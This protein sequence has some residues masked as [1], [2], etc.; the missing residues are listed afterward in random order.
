MFTKGVTMFKGVK[1]FA[2]LEWLATKALIM[3][4][5]LGKR[6]RKNYT[7][8]ATVCC[9]KQVVTNATRQF[10]TAQLYCLLD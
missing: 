8:T 3:S 7:N 9:Q 10:T 1:V 2:Q 4:A 5:K 6:Y